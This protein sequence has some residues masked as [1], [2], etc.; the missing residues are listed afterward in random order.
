MYMNKTK[1]LKNYITL[2]YPYNEYLQTIITVRVVNWRNVYFLFDYGSV[3]SKRAHTFPTPTLRHLSAICHL[4]WGL[5]IG[6]KCPTLG[7][8]Q[9]CIFQY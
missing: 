1:K 3:N 4:F 6:C 8:H 7:K 5:K 2:K 9:N